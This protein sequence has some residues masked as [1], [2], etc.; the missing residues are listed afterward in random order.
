MTSIHALPLNNHGEIT[1]KGKKYSLSKTET[2]SVICSLV[3]GKWYQN[4]LECF[5][6]NDWFQRPQ[7]LVEALNAWGNQYEMAQEAVDSSFKDYKKLMNIVNGCKYV[8]QSEVFNSLVDNMHDAWVDPGLKDIQ[9]WADEKLTRLRDAISLL[10]TYLEQLG[11]VH[12]VRENRL[13][14]L[15][16]MAAKKD[17][18]PYMELNSIVSD[19][20]LSSQEYLD[21]IWIECN[22]TS[23][24]FFGDTINTSDVLNFE[25]GRNEDNL[26]DELY[27]E[28]AG[29][30]G[31]K[32]MACLAQH[33]PGRDND[34][35]HLIID[36]SASFCESILDLRISASEL[37]KA[38]AIHLETVDNVKNII[39]KRDN[40]QKYTPE[41]MLSTVNVKKDAPREC[42][43]VAKLTD[44]FEAMT[45]A[46]RSPITDCSDALNTYNKAFANYSS[47]MQELRRCEQVHNL[48]YKILGKINELNQQFYEKLN[49]FPQGSNLTRLSTI[50]Y[51]RGYDKDGIF[52][53]PA[54]DAVKKD[55]MP[56]TFI[57]TLTQK[58]VN[59]FVVTVDT[60]NSLRQINP[61]AGYDIDRAKSFL[62]DI[63][64][65]HGKISERLD[66]WKHEAS[67]S[68]QPNIVTILPPELIRNN[69]GMQR[70]FDGLVKINA[71]NSEILNEMK[72]SQ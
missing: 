1:Y 14:V 34:L 47:E 11:Q 62:N 29:V 40:I 43:L 31:S 32:T 6:R 12:D 69:N 24:E 46:I 2:G 52:V 15:R 67:T 50:V 66:R 27:P 70:L 61:D 9:T 36:S 30:A 7:E 18:A 16:G 60:V 58:S 13:G 25:I 21:K 39:E 55:F 8:H 42:D 5:Y 65:Y 10:S 63:E 45:R 4:I 41:Q 72:P 19:A 59:E 49:D 71:I 3:G 37:T 38:H 17:M 53:R 23:P 51:T 56:N 26:L 54:S 48:E 20:S 68:Q 22:L 28:I 35:R 44:S 57:T 64:V 33:V